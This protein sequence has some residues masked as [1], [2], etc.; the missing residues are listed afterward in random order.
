MRLLFEE[1]G[2]LAKCKMNKDKKGMRIGTAYVEY[3]NP[4]DA[5]L[6]MKNCNGK[7]VGSKKLACEFTGTDTKGKQLAGR[8]DTVFCGNI[9]FYTKARAIREFFKDIGPIVEITFAKNKDGTGKG[10]CHL[11]FETPKEAIAAVAKDG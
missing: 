5:V 8:T 9:N 11:Q 2:P 1:F 6:G 3:D 10:F 4:V 7:T